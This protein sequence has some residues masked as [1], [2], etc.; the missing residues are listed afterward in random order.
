MTK[1]QMNSQF[2]FALTLLSLCLCLCLNAGAEKNVVGHW[3][4]DAVKVED[5]Y[6]V[7]VPHEMSKTHYISFILAVKDDGCEL[8]KLYAEGNAEARFKI[9]VPDRGGLLHPHQPL[10][11]QLPCGNAG[12]GAAVRPDL[13]HGG[14]CPLQDEFQAQG[15][16]L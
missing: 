14:L 5:E 3:Y 10:H 4:M 13:H 2:M 9:A 8:R 15:P 16:H 6:Y 1:N 11:F 12:G 7:S